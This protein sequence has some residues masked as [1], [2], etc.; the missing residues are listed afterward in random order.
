MSERL[1]LEQL[2]ADELMRRGIASARVGDSDEAERFLSE[3]IR[4]EPDNAEAWLWRAGV[5]GTPQA[6]RRYFEKVLELRPGDKEALAGLE[7]L[8]RK[9]GK[10]VLVDD[11]EDVAMRCTWHPDRETL[12]SCN[13]CGRPMCTE[14]AVQHPVGLRCKECIRE[15]RSPL[16]VVSPTGYV[17]AS[18]VALVCGTLAALFMAF[19]G[20]VPYAWLI[21]LFIGAGVGTGIAEA[22]SRGAGRKRGKGLQAVAVAGMLLGVLIAE[23]IL[24]RGMSGS[25]SF[26]GSRGLFVVIVYLAFGLGAAVARLR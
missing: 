15:L 26:I 13:R 22:V 3:V 4:R 25:F 10:A 19:L 7:Q 17:V 24:S 12:I 21:A 6:K 23:L 1:D 16:Y 18:V 20:L 5:A 14:C 8:S 2:D 9:Y 11:G